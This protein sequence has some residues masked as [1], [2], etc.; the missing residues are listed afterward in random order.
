M[1]FVFEAL[2][3]V[4]QRAAPRSRAGEM[5]VLE[6]RFLGDRQRLILLE[7]SGRTFLLGATGSTITQLAELERARV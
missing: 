3:R 5:K 1:R 6:Q 4:V 7:C 2:S